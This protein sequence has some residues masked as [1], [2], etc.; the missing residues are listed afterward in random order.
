MGYD[1]HIVRTTDWIDAEKNP[2]TKPDVDALIDRDREL[3]WS[4]SDF[5]DLKDRQTGTVV[6]YFSIAW[7]GQPCFW[8]YGGGVHCKSPKEHQIAKMVTMARS[9]HA[10]VV[11]DDKE[12]YELRRPL[13]GREKVVIV[14]P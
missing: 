12:R 9:L 13:L 1:V 6:R 14:R 2:I 4:N 8:W 5:V 7:K 11:G 10:Y 3:S